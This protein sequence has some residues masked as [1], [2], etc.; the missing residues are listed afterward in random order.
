MKLTPSLTAFFCPVY[1]LENSTYN[2]KVVGS[3]LIQIN[4]NVG[5]KLCQ[6]QFQ[7]PILVYLKLRKI[8]VAKW[9]TAK[10]VFLNLC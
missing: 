10:S 8:Q 2:Q 3:N 4:G 9:G 6:D 7:H 5:S 1:W